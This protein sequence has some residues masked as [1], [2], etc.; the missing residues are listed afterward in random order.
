MN[1]VRKVQVGIAIGTIIVIGIVSAAIWYAPNPELEAQKA[2]VN[3][4]A[5]QFV[6]IC[7]SALKNDDGSLAV[8]DSK[9]RTV[10]AETCSEDSMADICKDGRV[11]QWFKV[12][13]QS[14]SSSQQTTVVNLSDRID[15]QV[16]H[17]T[18]YRCFEQR[19]MS[20]IINDNSYYDMYTYIE[21]EHNQYCDSSNQVYGFHYVM[22]DVNR[23]MQ[24]NK[25]GGYKGLYSQYL[26]LDDTTITLGEKEI[27]QSTS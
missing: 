3:L 5:N 4:A 8:C 1:A 6:D 23:V 11:D 21:K 18:D 17:V 15:A 19:F 14:L 20:Y 2:K 25:D 13:Q 24:W 16:S 12:R 10:K 26:F 22:V 7:F 27:K 9:L